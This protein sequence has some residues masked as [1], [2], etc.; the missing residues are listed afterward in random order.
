MVFGIGKVGNR[1]GAR[2]IAQEEVIALHARIG[3]RLFGSQGSG[4]LNLR[5]RTGNFDSDFFRNS[6]YGNNNP[7]NGVIGRLYDLVELLEERV[8]ELEKKLAKKSK[9]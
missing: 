8:E 7:S 9:K 1:M 4:C 6:Y 3:T 5:T 2:E